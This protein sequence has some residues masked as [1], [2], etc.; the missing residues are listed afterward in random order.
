F[1][2]TISWTFGNTLETLTA[3]G[4]DRSKKGSKKEAVRKLMRTLPQ[5]EKSLGVMWKQMA[6]T[7]A[8]LLG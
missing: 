3:D 7:L 4:V 8:K 1:H 2:T 6:G 5:H